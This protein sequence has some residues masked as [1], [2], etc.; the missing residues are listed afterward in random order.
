MYAIRSYYGQAQGLQ[1]YAF[2]VAAQL[3]GQLD[4]RIL[5]Q[6]YRRVQLQPIVLQRALG[7]ELTRLSLILCLP[8]EWPVQ[9]LPV[10]LEA[11]GQCLA[12]RTESPV[13][14]QFS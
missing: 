10:S 9:L 13:Q 12:E 2:Q 1:H 3:E 6:L 7:T 8:L 4:G 5:R 14:F 11:E